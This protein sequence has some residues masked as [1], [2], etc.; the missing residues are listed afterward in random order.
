[1]PPARGINLY[2]FRLAVRT[3]HFG[4][5]IFLRVLEQFFYIGIAQV[6]GFGRACEFL[7]PFPVCTFLNIVHYIIE[8]GIEP[9]HLDMVRKAVAVF[10]GSIES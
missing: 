8:S 4:K 6:A 7:V 2:D 3:N 5:I 1:M 10:N 9:L